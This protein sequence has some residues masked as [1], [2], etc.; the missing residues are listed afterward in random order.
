MANTLSS[1]RLHDRGHNYYAPGIYHITL[2][3][4]DRANHSQLFG[5]LNDDLAA[6]AVKLNPLGLAVMDEWN[7]IPTHEATKGCKVRVHAAIC[8]PDHFHGVIE[9]LETMTKSVGQVIW[10]FKVACTKR[11]RSLSSAQAHLSQPIGTAT[12]GT[13]PTASPMTVR[14]TASLQ[15]LSAQQPIP[16]ID[17]PQPSLVAAAA[18]ATQIQDVNLHNMSARQRAEYYAIHPELQQ[19]LFDDN[20]DDTICIEGD[21]RHYKAMVDYVTDN[22]RRAILR[23]LRPDYM[24]RCQQISIWGIDD[25]GR[26]IERTYAAFGNLFLLQWPRKV[27]VFCHRKAPDRQTPWEQTPEFRAQCTT[28]KRLVM[29]GASVLVTPGIS[30]G[31][32]FIKRRCIE[33]GY[34]LIHIQK[35]PIGP[36]WK[37]ERQ[38][39]EACANGTLLILAPWSPE[40]LGEVKGVLSSTD[41]S[42][43]H[44]LN[45]LA[46]EICR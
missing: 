14:Q 32:Q 8:M 39:F 20:Y 10:G 19:P 40:A 30:R 11:W 23:R 28:W 34:P 7:K 3:A 24:Q 9:V 44:N 46:A 38:R 42:I 35:E 29:A 36:H 6:P 33:S 41:Y 21:E 37:P 25:D 43:F 5:Q 27:Q 13:Q 31:E 17:T 12:I 22:P 45:R 4:R 18:P 15:P 1:Y 2:V 26:P 16:P